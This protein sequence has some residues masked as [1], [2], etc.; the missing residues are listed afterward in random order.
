MGLIGGAWDEV[1]RGTGD[2]VNDG[3]HV[4]GDGLNAVGLHG[5]ANAVEVEGDKIG[6]SLGADV[7]E[8][9]LGQTS[10]PKQLVHG[11]A[12]KVRS[13]AAKLKTF[14]TG[15]GEVADGL[16]QIS[17]GHW[18]GAAADAFRARFAPEPAKWSAAATAMGEASGALT[19]YSSAV[20]AAQSQAQRAI[21]LWDQGQQVTKQAVYAYNQQVSAYNS[22]AQAYNARVQAGQDPG[23]RPSE[24]GKFTDPGAALRDQAQQ[25]L[26]AARQSRNAA[27]ASAAAAARRGTS[28]APAKPGLWSQLGDGLADGLSVAGLADVSMTTG[29]VQGAAD[30]V[31]FGRTLNPADQ[32]NIRH[33]AEYVA[34]VSGTLAGIADMEVNPRAAIQGLVGTGWGSDPFQAFG[35]LVPNIALTVLTDGGGAAADASDLS[36]L[37]ELS[38]ADPALN[39]AA[40]DAGDLPGVGDP[41]DVATGDVILRQ[42]DASLPGA[43]PLV[44]RR[45]H[46]SSQ[47][48]GR[49]FGESWVSSFDQRLLVLPDRVVA[50]FGGGQVLVYRRAELDDVGSQGLPVTGPCWPLTRVAED[51]YLVTD[52]QEGLTWRFEAHPAYW[53]YVGGQ[54]EFPL[55]SVRDRAGHEITFAYDEAGEPASVTHSGGQQVSV[56]VAGGRITE[57]SFGGAPLTRYAYNESGQLTEISNS[58]GQPLR[59]SYDDSGRVAG[60]TERNAFS[61]S[62][63]YDDLGRCVRGESPAGALSGTFEYRDGATWWTDATRAVTVY[64]LD[65][66]ARVAAVT[67][68]VGGVTRYAYDARGRK[69]A[70]T[71]PLG[72]VTRYAYDTLGNLVSVTRPDGAVARASYDD[73]CQPVTLEEPGRGSW[74]QDFDDLGNRTAL[75]RPDGGVVQYAYDDA[76]HLAAVTGPDGAVNAVTCDASGLPVAV[77]GPD[78]SVTSYQRDAFGRVVRMIDPAGAVTA[79]TWS[80]EGQPLSRTFPDGSSESWA[81]DADG[82]VL[83]HVSPGGAVSSFEYGPFDKVAAMTGPDGTRTSFG[84]DRELRLASV[85]HGRLAWSYDRDAAGRVVS[86]TDYNG[87]VTRYTLDAAGQVTRRLNAAG[88][89]VRYAYDAL[90]NVVSQA[91]GD[92]VTTFGYDE[93]GD[94]I[95]AEDAAVCLRFERDAFGQVTAESCNGR[96]I[97][98]WYDAAGRITGRA[99]PSGAVSSWAYDRAGRPD[100]LSAGGQRLRFEHGADGREMSRE[101]PGGARLAQDWDAL[102]R[103]TGQVLTGAAPRSGAVPD[104]GPTVLQQRRYAYDPDGYVTGIAD[105]VT[106]ARAFGLDAAGRVTTVS[107]AQ[108]AEHYSYDPAGNIA[109]A[110]WPAVPPEL[111]GG[112]LDTAPQ[113]PRSVSGTLTRQ[114]GSIRYRHDA[115]G[116]VVRRTRTRLSRKPETWRYEWD[117]DNRLTSV[118]MPDGSTWRYT[119]DP[120]GRRVGKQRTAPDAAVLAETRFTWDGLVLA[121]QAELVP[122]ACGRETVTTWDYHPGTFTPLTQATRTTFEGAPQEVI[123]SEFYAIIT[124]LTG[125]P[126]E[127][128]TPDGALAGFQQQ[129]LWGGT[130]WHPGGASTPLR[131]PGQYADDETGLHYNNQRYYDPATGAYLSPDPLGLAPAP[132]PHAYVSNPLVL[133]DPL[134]LAADSSYGAA[135]GAAAGAA[136]GADFITGTDGTTVPTSRARLE[137]GFRAVGLPSSP[138]RSAGM[139]YTLPDGSLV[140]IMEPSGSAPLRASF[141]DSYGNAIN[142][143]TGRQPMPPR[144]VSGAVWRQLMR[145]LT[146]VELGP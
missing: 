140:R 117:A 73:R 70:Q 103:L 145:S 122:G 133:T 101:L 110:A 45:V 79:M 40:R 81:R 118:V 76:G 104:A 139:Q 72:R 132:N 92:S 29:I 19:S 46:R 95:L 11:D 66:S 99:T 131:F 43:L 67:D 113:G 89:E 136:P 27:A 7:G 63:T 121:E 68:P 111:A 49:W 48:A 42:T 102:G 64:A 39:A 51:A 2:L 65:A 22:A 123:D 142:P 41:V 96:I 34:G 106:G 85:V 10:D 21:D 44:L 18:Q 15:F 86:E 82:N 16:N 32:W 31:K 93:A 78:G 38:N 112:W 62:Y 141:T 143:F 130:Y 69:T 108:W 125:T 1:K 138:T 128:V 20:E 14:Q 115:A 107:G 71:D 100:S 57:L 135:S 50:V 114:A 37:G 56:T 54:G 6:Y 52:R 8:L 12:G 9:Q 90:G 53:Q 3:A 84:Y 98:T 23:T 127:L 33:P 4:L 88:Q 13:T 83:E 47:R 129:T 109:S 55:A 126:S 119:Y 80:I 30:I 116:R 28:L 146:H 36:R 134:G 59:L 105:L 17:T 60:Y 58:S 91:A 26:S 5:A 77:T 24:P 35:K 75:T 87:A 144:G 74:R 61:Y 25:V 97:S 94:L 120:L 137:D 124:N